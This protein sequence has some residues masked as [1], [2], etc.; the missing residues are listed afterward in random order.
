[1]SSGPQTKSLRQ[2]SVVYASV[3]WMPELEA[4]SQLLE[5]LD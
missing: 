2:A 4:G 5:A 1:M 3:V